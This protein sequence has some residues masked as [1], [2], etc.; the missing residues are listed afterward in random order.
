MTPTP[1]VMGPLDWIT[2][3]GYTVDWTATEYCPL[4]F[5]EFRHKRRHTFWRQS[6]RE[7]YLYLG[8]PV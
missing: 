4:G 8:G 1:K 2:S 3:Q 6:I 7:A 5:I